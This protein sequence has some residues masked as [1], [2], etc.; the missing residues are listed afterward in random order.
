MSPHPTYISLG[1][2]Q[3][4][5]VSVVGVPGGAA[6]AGPFAMAGIV[7]EGAVTRMVS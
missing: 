1:P 4:Y 3:T 5:V 7:R 2:A 6:C